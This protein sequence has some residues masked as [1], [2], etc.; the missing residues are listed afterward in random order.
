MSNARITRDQ[1]IK[2]L[3]CNPETGILTWI[4]RKKGVR[5]GTQA[6]CINAD[7]YL[8]I[9]INGKRYYAHNLMWLYT[10]GKWPDPGK[11]IDHINGRPYDNRIKN[12]RCVSRTENNMNHTRLRSDNTSGYIGISYNNTRNKWCAQINI[13]KKVVGLGRFD[14][15]EEAIAVRNAKFKE[16]YGYLIE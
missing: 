16:I 6:G 2:I 9:G 12:L 8:F 7:G 14:S 11:E 1:L 4:Y 3:H 13:N 10:Y 5:V 15:L